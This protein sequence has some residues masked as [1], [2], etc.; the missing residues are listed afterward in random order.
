[1]DAKPFKNIEE[2]I[3]ILESRGMVID[4]N[5]AK[6]SLMKNG[7]YNIINGYKDF[8]LK[9]DNTFIEGT[10][11]YDLNTLFE[12]DKRLSKAFFS[13]SLD[14]ERMFKTNLAYFLSEKYGE[15][16]N[17]YL[18]PKNYS[19]GKN[20]G[21]NTWQID[22]TIA[23]F[24]KLISQDVEPIT[25][26]KEKY[27]NVPP[28]ILFT[29][30]TFGNV[31]YLFKLSKSDI[32]TKV[33]SSIINKDANYIDDQT[34]RLFSDLML[35]ILYF[36]NRTAH[37]N[38]TYNFKVNV[39]NSFLP[40]NNIFYEPFNISKNDHKNKICRT[41][42]FAFI[43][44][45]YYLDKNNYAYLREQVIQIL[46]FYKSVQPKNYEKLLLAIGFPE[47]FKDIKIEKLLPEI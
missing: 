13:A 9:D 19:T 45:I 39:S 23:I 8:F 37:A 34:K 16:E 26:Y 29:R 22:R 18:N 20:L 12:I 11:F 6:E 40:Y 32:K 7:Y 27:S 33:I 44:S 14:I 4:H 21:N 15:K 24:K 41:D 5:I 30:A 38:R 28:W 10:E 46:S 17:N 42:A 1:M 35:L 31:Y 36:R 43:V 47:K 3:N 2:Q 25:H